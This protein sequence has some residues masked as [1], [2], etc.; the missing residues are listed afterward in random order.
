MV[1]QCY[2]RLVQ[3]EINYRSIFSV[4]LCDLLICHL[5]S[6]FDRKE[7]RNN[8]GKDDGSLPV[9]FCSRLRGDVLLDVWTGESGKVYATP[10]RKFKYSKD[11]EENY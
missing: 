6:L 7:I 11:L 3:M 1:D 9:A 4:A 5:S 8:F 10:I 2:T